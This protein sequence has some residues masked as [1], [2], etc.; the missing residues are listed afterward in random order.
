MYDVHRVGAGSVPFHLM[1]LTR[2]R[3]QV[4]SIILIGSSKHIPGH[5]ANRPNRRN[6]GLH[7][8]RVGH[9]IGQV[10]FPAGRGFGALGRNS[11]FGGEALPGITREMDPQ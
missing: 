9:C 5:S 8:H 10:S 1:L 7:L 6:L 4:C 11:S 2:L 3:I